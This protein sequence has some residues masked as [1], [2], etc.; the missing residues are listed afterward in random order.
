LTGKEKCRR[1]I[2]DSATCCLMRQATDARL[3]QAA[4]LHHSPSGLNERHPEQAD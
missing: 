1:D 4:R 3:V 2:A